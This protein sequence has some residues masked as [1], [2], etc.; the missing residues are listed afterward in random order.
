MGNIEVQLNII[1]ACLIFISIAIV[2][3]AVSVLFV[4]V[5]YYFKF[6][7]KI[8]EVL[9]NI[10]AISDNV[11]HISDFLT[12]EVDRAKDTLNGVHN[13][14]TNISYTLNTL[15]DVTKILINNLN[16]ANFTKSLFSRFTN[17]KNK[18]KRNKDLEF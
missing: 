1:A 3:L 7:K 8:D 13:A 15:S 17:K 16:L 14:F 6:S 11:H 9:E 18:I 5:T 2:I 12:D 10:K 4:I